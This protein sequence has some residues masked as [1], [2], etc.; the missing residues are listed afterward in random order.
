MRGS[1]EAGHPSLLCVG[2]KGLL[3]VVSSIVLGLEILRSP[4]TTSLA[5]CHCGGGGSVCVLCIVHCGRKNTRISPAVHPFQED[6]STPCGTQLWVIYV[7]C[8]YPNFFTEHAPSCHQGNM[9][10]NL[11]RIEIRTG[12]LRNT[13]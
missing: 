4:I 3:A 6:H 12:Y 8:E 1:T 2:S 10:T 9:P 5:D 13:K 11:A 7:E